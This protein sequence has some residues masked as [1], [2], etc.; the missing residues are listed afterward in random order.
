M[1]EIKIAVADGNG[2]AAPKKQ[3]DFALDNFRGFVILLLIFF[4][5]YYPLKYTP[6]FL[7]HSE[8]VERLRYADFI[9]PC[10]MFALSAAYSTGLRKY[11]GAVGYKAA[12]KKYAAR[13]LALIG[14]GFL[15]FAIPQVADR[16]MKIEFNVFSAYGIAGLY[17]LF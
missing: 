5:F 4:F 11:T 8:G 13:F 6:W 14:I 15:L 2:G 7:M 17:S 10:F 12:I 3:R 1:E 9:A 16:D